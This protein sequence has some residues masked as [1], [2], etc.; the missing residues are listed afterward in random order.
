MKITIENSILVFDEAHN[1]QSVAEDQTS[2]EISLSDLQYVIYL[3]SLKISQKILTE[4][5]T[6]QN[7]R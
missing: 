2:M 5:S 6:R 1:I 4:K 7:E 3:D